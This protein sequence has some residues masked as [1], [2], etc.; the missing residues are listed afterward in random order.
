[1]DPF[2]A[3]F[4]WLFAVGIA[5]PL[6]LVW[7][8]ALF[9]LFRRT[10]LTIGRK[11]VW[12]IVIVAGVFVGTA[13]YFIV[14]PARLPPGKDSRDSTKQSS[15]IVTNLEALRQQHLDGTLKDD[16]YLK[17]KQKLLGLS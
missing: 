16:A 3:T 5:I 13:A 9:D 11:V 10:D 1:M 8:V 7:L 15:D 2:S 12:T 14:R 4:N 17:Q 6:A